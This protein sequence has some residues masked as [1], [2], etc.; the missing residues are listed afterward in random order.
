MTGPLLSAVVGADAP[1]AALPQVR[2]TPSDSIVVESPL[3]GGAAE[4][5]RFALNVVPPLAQVAILLGA[6]AIAL[7]VVR[8]LARRRT[9]VHDWFVSRSRALRWTL[10]GAGLLLLV[11]VGSMGTATWAYTQHSNDFCTGCHVMNPAFQRFSADENKHGELSCH[12]CHQQSPLASARQLYLWVAERPERIGEHA[13]VPNRVCETCHVTADTAVWQRI[14]ATAGHRVHLESD[15]ASLKGL[16]CVTCH[17]VEVHR[18]RPVAET[19]GQSECHKPHDTEIVLGKM[20]AQTVRHCTSCHPFTADVPLLATRDSARGSLV[21][22]ETEC[23][24][25]H[26]MQTVLADFSARKDP[27]GGKCG[28]CHDPHTQ[29]TPAAATSCSTAGCHDTWRDNP[30]H[31]GENH[32]R[33]GSQCITC[34]QPHASR[35]DASDCAG[36]HV[37]VRAQGRLRPPVPFDTAAAARRSGIPAAAPSPVASEVPERGAR[38]SGP[39]VDESSE[40]GFELFRAHSISPVVVDSFPHARHLS[41]ACLECHQTGTGHGRLTFE[42]PRGCA[43]CHHQSPATA[44]CASCHRPEQYGAVKHATVTVTVPDRLPNPRAVDFSHDRHAARPCIECHTTPVTLAPGP[45][46]AQCVDCHVEHHAAGRDC[47]ACHRIAEPRIEHTPVEAAHQ[48][49]DACHTASSVARL[50]PTRSFC[51]TCHATQATG[52]HDR[53]EC[54]SCHFLAEPTEYR[55]RLLT[56]PSK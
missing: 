39:W 52:H 30:F 2:V 55:A 41:V 35:V 8:T 10:A 46:K 51:T 22:G 18:F 14:A 32:K 53:R 34:H 11:G 42:R 7:L 26:E 21:P 4:V 12:D 27:H 31:S 38:R 20:G 3:P 48:R 54:T 9:Q 36:C 6:A 40:P 44:K 25:C 1:A 37:R 47:T 13:K 28:S 49:C 56:P 33:V 50:T 45:S 43:L 16:Q 5:I 17:G 29:K 19:C 24:G 15:S 23:L